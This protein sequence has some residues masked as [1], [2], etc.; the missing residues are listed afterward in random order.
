[1]NGI[2]QANIQA[3][4]ESFKDALHISLSDLPAG[5]T[6]KH[7]AEFAG[8]SYSGLWQCADKEQSS[9]ISVRRL[10]RILPHL[11]NFA[12]LDYL[13]TLVGRIAF[14]IPSAREMCGPE[15]GEALKEFGEFVVEATS[16]QWTPE[17]VAR[18]EKEGRQAMASIATIIECA[19]RQAEASKA[20]ALKAVVR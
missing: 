18:I 8:I 2:E 11:K 3:K 7:L 10:I 6:V 5:R 20:P 9:W 16:G 13:E 19:K 12:V 14:R 17:K 15:M 4:D 1:M